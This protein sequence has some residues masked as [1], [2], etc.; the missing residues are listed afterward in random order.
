MARSRDEQAVIAYRETALRAFREVE[1]ALSNLRERAVQADARKRAADDARRVFEASQK[2]YTEGGMSYFEVIDAQ[3]VLLN[4]ELSKV[5]T[6][7]NRYSATVDLVRALGG[8]FEGTA[9]AS[10]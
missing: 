8:G 4:A 5:R 2:S 9:D 10:K 1:D 3:R 7:S 6:L